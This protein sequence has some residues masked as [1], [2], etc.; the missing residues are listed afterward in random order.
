MDGKP[1]RDFTYDRKGKIVTVVV[2][3]ARGG[4]SV[5]VTY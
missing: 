1:S 2:P 5:T 3:Y 4:Q